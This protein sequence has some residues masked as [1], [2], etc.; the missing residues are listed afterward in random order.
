MFRRMRVLAAAL[1]HSRSSLALLSCLVVTAPWVRAQP[2]QELRVLAGHLGAV[3]AAEFTPDGERVITVSSDETAKLWDAASGEERQ[4]FR[5][6][7]GP[8]YCL[9]ISG[10]GRVLATG[11]Q[12]NT[13]RIWDIPQSR[14]IEWLAAHQGPATSFAVSPDNQ[15]LVSGGEDQ[16]LRVEL[17]AGGQPPQLRA[18]HAA[19]ITRIAYRNDNG[20][21]ASGDA[22]GRLLLWSPFLETPQFQFGA[23]LGPLTGLAY[24]PNNQQI[25]TAGRDGL[26]RLWQPPLAAR[27]PLP[28][29]AEG[30]RAMWLVNNQPLAVTG[31]NDKVVRVLDLNSGQVQREIAGRTQPLAA[32]G[33]SPNNGVLAGGDDTGEVQLWNFG[34]GQPLAR[35]G[36]HTAAVQMLSFHGDQQ[37]W[38]SLANDGTWRVWSIPVPPISLAGHSQPATRAAFSSDG[39]F[40]VTGSADQTVRVWNANGQAVRALSHHQAPV[41]AVALRPDNTQVASGDEQGRIVLANP[42]DGTLQAQL[43]AHTAAITQ[44]RYSADGQFLVTS[45]S[46]GTLKRWRL[47]VEPPRTLSGHGQAVRDVAATADGSLAVTASLDQTIRVWQTA[48]GQQVR[49]LDNQLGP[50]QAVAIHSAANLVAAGGDAGLLQ[51]WQLSDG[52]PRWRL[53]NLG[54]AVRDLAFHPGSPALLSTTADGE[55]RLWQLGEPARDLPGDKHPTQSCF[56]NREG[57]RLAVCATV[58]GK[59]AVVVRDIASGTT[60]GTWLHDGPVTCAAFNADSSRLASGSADRTI[61]VWNVADPNAPALLKLE[62]QANTISAVALSDD[63]GLVFASAGDAAIRAWKVA[64]GVETRVLAGHGA[65]VSALCVAG[66]LLYSASHDGTARSWNVSDGA[67]VRTFSHGGQLTSLA[68]SADGQTLATGGTDQQLKLWQTA[69]GSLVSTAPAAGGTITSC[70]L[71][72]S[73]TRVVGL[74]NNQF[75]RTSQRDGR[76]LER[77]ELPNAVPGLSYSADEQFI[78]A[79]QSD[80]TIK[81]L[82]ISARFAAGTSGVKATSVAW[83]RD[84][85]TLLAGT[86]DKTVLA[87]DTGTG[88]LQQTFRGPTETVTQLAVSA[89]GAWL[90]AAST[91]KLVHLWDFTQRGADVAASKSFAHPAAVRGVAFDAESANLATTGDD[92]FVRVWD[93]A[94]GRERERFTGHT[95]PGTSVAFAGPR[96]LSGAAD[97]TARVWTPAAAQ[98]WI[99]SATIVDLQLLPEEIA[100]LDGASAA[101]QTVSLTDKPARTFAG[102]TSALTALTSAPSQ[103][104]LAAC[105][106]QGRVYV[107]SAENAQLLQTADSGS[108]LTALAF[109]PSGK[110]LATA[111]NQGR[112]RIL[113]AQEKLTLLEDFDAAL[114]HSELAWSPDGRGLV[115]GAR[116][117]TAA[118]YRP[119]L[120]RHTVVHAAGPVCGATFGNGD[121]LLSG[122]ADGRLVFSPIAEGQPPRVLAELGQA[123]TAIAV[124]ND[125][126]RV[127]AATADRVVR[128][129]NTGDAALLATWPHDTGVSCLAFTADGQRLAVGGTEGRVTVLDA[130]NWQPLEYFF[131]HTLAVTA[132]R[133]LNDNRTFYSCSLD[134]TVQSQS[135]TAQRVYAVH[136]G[137]V[138]QLALLTGGGQFVTCGADQRTVLWDTGSG[139]QQRVFEGQGPA[140]KLAVRSDNQRLVTGGDDGQLHLWNLGSGEHLASWPIGQPLVALAFSPDNQKIAVSDRERSVHLLAAPNPAQPGVEYERRQHFVA[141]SAALQLSF[142]SDNRVVRACHATGQL[143]Q[144]AYAS[145]LPVR[146][147]NHGGPV[148]GLALNQDGSVAVSC[149]ADQ[150]VRIWDNQTGGQRAQLNGHQGSVYGLALTADG[151]LAVSSGND[152]TLRLWDS[153]RRTG[154]T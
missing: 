121:V 10:N 31:G 89:N 33:L 123:V 140:T 7:T 134:K 152:G 141:E 108:P 117:G 111:T 16:R 76:L 109:D 124:T 85:A 69:D 4:T 43:G 55:V 81:W 28:A 142:T 107:W 8:V 71:N 2:P 95:A 127:A 35:V 41:T 23:H 132:V 154:E 103:Q 119:R 84:G 120:L 11:A 59:H 147:F 56:T 9:A 75:L 66:P 24:H 145:P 60:L 138:E 97:N 136:E 139:Q 22:Q 42:Q 63:G 78:V 86:E 146:Q 77:L 47:P 94:L 37:R 64:D 149:S 58:A 29:H 83:G 13:V 65:A 112:L 79:A 104:R 19:A 82:P 130:T 1:R 68:L 70:G 14:P 25:L 100:W 105:D 52:A 113:D 143:G 126:S 115:A 32:L 38:T 44:V 49:A 91:D 5:A 74:V 34:D 46:D 57:T 73:G 93:L 148:F 98:F 48:S 39:Q 20:Q 118:L 67:A 6:H 15:W 92:T 101:V 62:N 99:A 151:A 21:L 12:D 144:W 45:A 36:G 18:G 129:W 26:V 17:L 137:G 72:A 135:L 50:V 27:P 53:Q 153:G 88:Q 125:G 122:G 54:G 90:A 116:T 128:V 61:R 110:K 150:T 133:F 96:V 114:D 131:N 51:V 102:A 40:F 3:N 87:F 106:V 80:G 30:V